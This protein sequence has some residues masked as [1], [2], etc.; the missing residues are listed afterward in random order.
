[1]NFLESLLEKLSAGDMPNHFT[2]AM[3]ELIRKA[4]EE[5]GYSQRDLA[6][7]IFRRQAALSD[8]EN[9]KM[10][11]N[12]ST[13]TLLSHYLKKPISYFFPDRYTPEKNLGEFSD[14]EKEILM[15][16]KQLDPNDQIKI[17]AQIKALSKL[18]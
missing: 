13:L 12:A 8:M 1:M 6:Q 18:N 7:K 10:E 2:R 17:Q 4:R 14:I 9:G 16:V 11:P 5:S 15:Y 3:G